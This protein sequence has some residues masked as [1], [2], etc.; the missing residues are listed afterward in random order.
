ME[1]NN[2]GKIAKVILVGETGVGKTALI[3]R[4]I[5]DKFNF[6]TMST[7]TASFEEKTITLNDENKTKIAFR[8]WDTCGQEKYRD[9]ANIFFNDTKAVIL[10]YDSTS[11]QSFNEMK[12]YWY[13][14]VKESTDENIVLA[15]ASNKADLFDKE[16]I[17]EEEG[18][19][20]A[21]E[22]NALFMMTSAYTGLGINEL[23][24]NIGMKVATLKEN[25]NKKGNVVLS[26]KKNEDN[27][28][29]RKCC[30]YY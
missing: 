16:E 17:S 13:N 24:E 21:N 6:D 23:F 3:Y 4:Y 5:N 15:V 9:L 26:S 22:I 11:R 19:A 27:Y 20:Y 29:N 30:Y 10:V 1:E 7:I 28:N 8:I 14:K 2:E 12:N 18:T 25:E